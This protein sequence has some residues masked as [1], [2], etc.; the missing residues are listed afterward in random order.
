MKKLKKHQEIIEDFEKVKSRHIEKLAT[1][2][3]KQDEKFKKFK[4]YKNNGKFLD[5]F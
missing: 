5:N 4:K 1:K 2:I 3:L